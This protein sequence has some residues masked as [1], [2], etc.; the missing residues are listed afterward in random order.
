MNLPTLFISHGGGPWPWIDERRA[1][2]A[3]TLRWLQQLPATLPERPAAVLCISGHWE[4]PEFT[5]ATSAH[6]PMVYDY[7]G[8]PEH[9]YRITYPAPGAP[10][11]ARRVSGLLQHAGI[12]IDEDPGRGFDHGT[13]V[14]LAVMYPGADMPI[15]SLSLRTSLNAGEHLRMG[16][17]L[18]PLRAAGVL[19]VGSG[20][21][22]HNLRALRSSATAGP[23]SEQFEAWLTGTIEDPDTAARVQRLSRWAEAPAARLAHPREEHLIPLMVAAGAA[24]NSRGRLAFRDH[25]WGVSMASYRFGD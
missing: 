5:L 3:G 18:E 14:P 11:L 12:R 7:Y 1:E 15:L 23:V 22:Y 6:P 8:F 17:A 24:G 10:A 4:E 9:T 25:V 13:F 2:F 21:S 20:L 16:A 19:I